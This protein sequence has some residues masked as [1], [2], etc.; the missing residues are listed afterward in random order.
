MRLLAAL[1]LSLVVPALYANNEWESE[2]PTLT[3]KYEIIGRRCDSDKLYTGRITIEE[4]RPN[5][6]TVTRVIGT[7]TTVGSGKVEWATPDK[8]KVFRI[9]FQEDGKDM[10]GT[11]LWRSDLDN[12]GRISGYVYP[13]GYR[14]V[15][16]GLE[17][18]FAEKKW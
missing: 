7:K 3:G 17:A 16:P 14:G 9:R 2:L 5:E 8:I 15:K 13:I 18:L 6:F 11:F 1:Y 10:G 12:D 4:K